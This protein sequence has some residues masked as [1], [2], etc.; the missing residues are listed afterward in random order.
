M[1]ENVTLEMS[2]KPFKKT[3]EEYIR[4]VCSQMFDKWHALLKNRKVV[5]VMLWVGDGSEI[6]EYA[7]NTDEEIEWAR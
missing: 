6:L 7:G 3:N 1:F 5:S 2:L 4:G